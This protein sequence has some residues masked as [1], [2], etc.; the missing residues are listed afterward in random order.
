MDVLHDH[1][2][3]H[4]KSVARRMSWASKRET[5]RMEDTAYCL[6]G[7]F[8]VNMPLLYGEGERAFIRLQEEIMRS[9][10]DHSLFAWD[11]HF[12]NTLYTTGLS[13]DSPFLDVGVLAPHPVAFSGSAN[14]TPHYTKTEPYAMTNRGV[15][16]YLRI[17]K[18]EEPEFT[19]LFLPILQCGYS[20]SLGT[21]LAIPFEQISASQLSESKDE[22]CRAAD[23]K[24]SRGEILAGRIF[25]IQKVYL[26]EA[27]LLFSSRVSLP[28]HRC[29]L[30]EYGHELGVK[31]YKT[32]YCQYPIKVG[33]DTSRDWNNENIS[34]TWE[35]ASRG[36]RAALFFFMKDGPAFVIV[37]TVIHLL[38]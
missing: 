32:R 5:S 16:I 14:I 13:L 17:F 31:V 1:K 6:M 28:F 9:E 12:P 38:N 35:K 24:I 37:L 15:Q 22:F 18:K 26:F 23:K 19:Q 33:D 29:W 21:A 8:S 25:G 7:I 30:R 36:V 2:L 4:T 34:M 27:E 3:L 11:H 20:N 10:Y